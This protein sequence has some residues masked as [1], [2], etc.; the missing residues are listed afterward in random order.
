M[1]GGLAAAVGMAAATRPGV[2]VVA[3]LVAVFATAAGCFVG[4]CLVATGWRFT[5]WRAPLAGDALRVTRRLVRRVAFAVFAAFG[6]SR[7]RAAGRAD[8]VDL[9]ALFFFFGAAFLDTAFLRTTC[10]RLA[11]L[12]TPRAGRALATR[13]APRA[14]F[15][16]FRAVARAV[17]RLAIA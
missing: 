3:D 17:L 14:G 11:P 12:R 16:P 10:F 15:V 9:R 2:L 7:F 1:A 8:D 5:T 13:P 4:A 6:A